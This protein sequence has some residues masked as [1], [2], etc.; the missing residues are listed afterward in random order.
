MPEAPH[1]IGCACGGFPTCG[2]ALPEIVRE[3]HPVVTARTLAAICRDLAAGI[4]MLYETYLYPDLSSPKPSRGR[5][6]RLLEMKLMAIDDLRQKVRD[7][8]VL[9]EEASTE[10][11]LGSDYQRVKKIPV[12]VRGG[13]EI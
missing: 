1:R 13:F 7:G 10:A 6:L 11:E 12:V 3:G 8:L 9:A 2:H 4:E 5:V